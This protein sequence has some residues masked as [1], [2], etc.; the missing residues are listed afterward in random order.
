MYGLKVGRYIVSYFVERTMLF[1]MLP[2]VANALNKPVPI[3]GLV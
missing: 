3:I 2:S 1:C